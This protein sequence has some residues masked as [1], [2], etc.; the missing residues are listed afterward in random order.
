[1]SEE[2]KDIEQLLIGMKNYITYGYVDPRS[3]DTLSNDL[4]DYLSEL[5]SLD[6]K[7]AYFYYK[8]Y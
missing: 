5:T 3:F 8:K 1:M 7:K 4:L 2:N 6:S